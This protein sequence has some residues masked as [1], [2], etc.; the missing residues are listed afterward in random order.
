[1]KEGSGR[2]RNHAGIRLEFDGNRV[3]VFGVFFIGHSDEEK[4]LTQG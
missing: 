2:R 4:S 1:M 3:G